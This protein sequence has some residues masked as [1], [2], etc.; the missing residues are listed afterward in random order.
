MYFALL[1]LVA[2]WVLL[3]RS[4]VGFQIKVL[5]LDK[6]A[7]GFVGFREKRLVWLALLISG[8]LAGLAGVSEVTGPI[9]QLFQGMM[10]FFLLACDVLILYRPRLKLHWAKRQMTPVTGAA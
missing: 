4:F 3:Q 5:G 2:V 1:A 7:A 9:G 8:A 6:R 10:L